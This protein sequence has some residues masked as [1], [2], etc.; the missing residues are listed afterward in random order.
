MAAHRR[1]APVIA[2]LLFIALLVTAP[3][4]AQ[5]Q[6]YPARPIRLIITTPAGGLVD[7]LGRLFAEE[8]A[9]PLG[10][11]LVIDNRPGGMTQVGADALNRA[12]PDGYTL[13][14]GTSES[15]M[16]PVL[17]K[18]Y[19]YDPIRDFTPIALVASSWTVFAVNPGVPAKSLP[20]LVAYA[21]ANP[22]KLRYG[23]GGVGGALHI[24]VEMFKLSAGVDIVHVPYRG[25][26][27]AATDAISGQID[28]VSMG[29]ASARVA[30]GGKL[31]ILAQTGP[32]RHPLFPDVPT[33]AEVGLPDVRMET[34]F[35]LTAP[36]ATPEPIVARLNRAIEAVAAS[37]SF[38]E[39]LAKIGCAVAFLPQP[40]FVEFIRGESRKWERLIPAMGIPAID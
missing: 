10:Q 22:G 17:K 6:D 9:A 38:A 40:R 39:R 16:L 11:P 7:V 32:S 30:E 12:A 27:Q 37:K 8:M 13:M 25:G 1:C 36:P 19:R 18:S 2:A 34:W 14:V 24:A 5:A 4:A 29:L 35:G 26:A 20:E 21:K 15:T 28:M 3:P 23:S 31:R 33:T